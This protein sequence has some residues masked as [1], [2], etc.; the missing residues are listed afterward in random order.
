MDNKRK[1]LYKYLGI[2]D[3]KICQKWG[4]QEHQNKPILVY[5]NRKYHVLDRHLAEFGSKEE[6]DKVY[7]MLDSIIKKPDYVFY[8]S[9][10]KGLE[11]YKEISYDVCAAV[12]IK[13]GRVLK[14]KSWYPANEG[15]I[16]NRKK[17][18]EEILGQNFE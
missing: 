12:E 18:E 4:I 1:K 7:D 8:N 6:I 9:S 3:P 2:L 16:Q 5:E 17:K 15:K 11:Y 10:T 13:P 14:V